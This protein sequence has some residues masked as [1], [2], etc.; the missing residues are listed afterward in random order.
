MDD[1]KQKS[2]FGNRLFALR[3]EYGVSAREMSLALGQAHSFINGIESGKNFPSM[4]NFFY[5][6]E[7]LRV[8]PDEFFDYA[9]KTPKRDAELYDAIQKLDRKSK[10]YILSVIHEIN[11]RPK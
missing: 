7:Y 1:S 4:L 8:T 9:H 3:E 6:C 5:I 11:N 2:D 10:E